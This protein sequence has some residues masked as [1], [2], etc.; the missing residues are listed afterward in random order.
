[1]G[2]EGIRPPMP[3]PNMPLPPD[4]TGLHQDKALNL[5]VEMRRREEEMRRK[6]EEHSMKMEEREKK[7]A[8]EREQERE[9]NMRR[10]MELKRERLVGDREEESPYAAMLAAQ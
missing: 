10:E 9:R 8:D 5:H 1:M 6:D 2:A 4:I 7:E 3:L